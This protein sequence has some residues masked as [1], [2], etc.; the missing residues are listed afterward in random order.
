MGL[1]ATLS[2]KALEMAKKYEDVFM[3]VGCHP[4]EAAKMREGDLESLGELT[5]DSRVVAIGEIG[6]D[7]YRNLS[8]RE[9]QLEAFGKQLDLAVRLSLPVVIHCRQAHREVYDI[10]SN[11]VKANPD[12]R[13]GVIHCFSGDIEM[14]RRYIELGFY[15]SLAGSV[16]YPSARELVEV[17]REIPLERLLLETDAPFLA[18]QAHRGQRNEPLYVALTAEK[19]AGI[20]QVPVEV[21]ADSAARN[22]IELFRLPMS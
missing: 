2:R 16:T 18:P 20:R 4:H 11:W 9:S 3:A 19:V 13:R 1:D 12:S 6:L 14:A 10:L 8:P 15:V 22:T 17:A 21:V 7:F 5:K